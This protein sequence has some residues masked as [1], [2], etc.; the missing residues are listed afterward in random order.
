MIDLM[1]FREVPE[2]KWNLTFL[3]VGQI[4]RIQESKLEQLKG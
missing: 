2:Y 3:D 4:A 1:D